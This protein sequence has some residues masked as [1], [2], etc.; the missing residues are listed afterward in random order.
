M[1]PVICIIAMVH[2]PVPPK[3]RLRFAGHD[4]LV[5]KWAI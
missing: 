1:L 5:Q 3:L 2:C 4:E